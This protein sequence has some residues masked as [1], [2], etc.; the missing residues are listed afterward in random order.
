MNAMGRVVARLRSGWRRLPLVRQLRGVTFR[1]LRPLRE[2][3]QTGTAVVRYHWARFLE[4]HRS[5]IRGRALEVGATSTI[6]RYGG[7][8]LV[9]ADAID[10]SPHGPD[11]TVAADLS[12]ADAVPSDT[13]DCFVNQFTM[14]VIYDVDAAL[15]HAVR[16]LRPGGVLLVNFP[17]VDYY[18]PTGLDMGT[19][20]PMFLYWWFTP[21]HVETL[22]RRAGLHDGDYRLQVYGNLFTRIAYQL[23]MPAEEL[24]RRELE[25]VDPGHPLL[26]CVRAVKPIGWR[27]DRPCYRDPWTPPGQPVRWDP[28]TGHYGSRT[29]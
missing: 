22:L 1:R 15:Y 14:H 27:A 16:I 17:C 25:T 3:R 21:I 26:I 20:R 24:T 28:V 13:W 10:L 7:P 9:R 11:V 2:G 6:R 5:D 18:F 8:N 12:R 23:N 19:G 4:E 29:A